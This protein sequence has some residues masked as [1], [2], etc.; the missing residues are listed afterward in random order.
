VR[1]AVRITTRDKEFTIGCK[2]YPG[3]GDDFIATACKRFERAGV[4][5]SG[6]YVSVAIPRSIELQCIGISVASWRL[7]WL[8]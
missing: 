4:V 1:T 6:T 8:S 3:M 7:L 5:T 2:Q